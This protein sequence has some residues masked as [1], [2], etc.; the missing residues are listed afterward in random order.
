MTPVHR[1]E[2]IVFTRSSLSFTADGRRYSCALARI[3][4]RLAHARTTELR[5]YELSPSGYGIHWPLLDEDLT[6]DG[7]I[8]VAESD[9]GEP[10]SCRHIHAGEGMV[11][12]EES[13]PYGR[14]RRTK[15]ATHRAP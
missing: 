6:V 3:S 7:L 14:A 15:P 1:V 10:E 2:N 5:Q 11:T 4:S 12:R 9:T 8:R 13:I